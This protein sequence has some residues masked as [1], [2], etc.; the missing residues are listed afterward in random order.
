MW[1]SGCGA[2]YPLELLYDLNDARKPGQNPVPA[3]L[4]RA[5]EGG[6]GEGS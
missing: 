3:S 5:G 6:G 1:R 4:K 2:M